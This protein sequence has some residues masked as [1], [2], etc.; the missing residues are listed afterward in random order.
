MVL[1]KRKC[2]LKCRKAT[3]AVNATRSSPTLSVS[4]S[5]PS[6]LHISLRTAQTT[7]L[8]EATT[9]C[10]DGTVRKGTLKLVLSMLINA[11]NH[12]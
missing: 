10:T 1:V 11:P 2:P 12:R 5:D 6:H 3:I 8:D 9:I 7:R 4:G